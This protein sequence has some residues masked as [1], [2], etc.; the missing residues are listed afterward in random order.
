MAKA[1]DL[2]K[3]AVSLSDE[4][5]LHFMELA[6]TLRTLQEV[7]MGQFR[8]CIMNTGIGLRKAYYLVD[9]DKT[10]ETLKIAPS[11]LRKIGWTK[12]MLIAKQINKQNAKQL[13]QW[14]EDNTAV[15]LKRLLKGEKVEDNS[16]CVML[17]FSPKQFEEFAKVLAAHGGEVSGRSIAN[18][19]EALMNVIKLAKNLPAKK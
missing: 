11:R 19:E 1:D 8:D 9:I 17:Y 3:K 5:D 13:L 4:F 18:K 15:A 6:K 7:D 16:H 12:L 2:Y 10:F 14:A